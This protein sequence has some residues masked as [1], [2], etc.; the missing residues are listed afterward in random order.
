MPPLGLI[1]DVPTALVVHPSLPVYS[2]LRPTAFTAL[3]FF[4][5]ESCTILRNSSGVPVTTSVA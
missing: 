4:S 3:A 2:T 5:S 1:V